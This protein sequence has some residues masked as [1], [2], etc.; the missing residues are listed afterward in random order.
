MSHTH[1]TGLRLGPPG[2]PFAVPAVLNGFYF[3]AVN[4]PQSVLIEDWTVLLT[5]LACPGRT[6]GAAIAAA[7][8]I[9]LTPGGIEI[10][11]GNLQ[12]N[13]LKNVG[14]QVAPGTKVFVECDSVASAATPVNVWLLY[15]R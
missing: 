4:A 11:S 9:G 15:G 8:S 10:F 6:A 3:T 12:I 1:L 14:Y 13:E 7:I 5:V 2:G